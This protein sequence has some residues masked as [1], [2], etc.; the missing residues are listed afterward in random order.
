MKFSPLVLPNKQYSFI[1]V[2]SLISFV[3]SGVF[4]ALQTSLTLITMSIILAG[5][6]FVIFVYRREWFPFLLVF[7]LG[8]EQ[9]RLSEIGVWGTASKIG[10]VALVFVYLI[11]RTRHPSVRRKEFLSGPVI[12]L[13]ALF[14]FMLVS[15]LWSQ[16][17]ELGPV[18][19]T[20]GISLLAMSLLVLDFVEDEID[21]RNMC[22]A[23]LSYGLV[24]S[25][26]GIY[27][28]FQVSSFVTE[29]QFRAVSLTGN[30]NFTAAYNIIATAVLLG[31]TAVLTNPSR[32]TYILATGMLVILLV[33]TVLTASRAS[34]IA[35]GLVYLIAFI[36]AQSKKVVLTV[37][38][39]VMGLSL[40]AFIVVPQSIQ[41][42]RLRFDSFL[43]GGNSIEQLDTGL[44]LQ[45]I[46][47][48]LTIL[49]ESPIV[50]IGYGSFLTHPLNP[51]HRVTHG[52]FHGILVEGGIIGFILLM[53]LIA[54]TF[55]RLWLTRKSFTVSDNHVGMQV[56]LSLF[57][58]FVGFLFMAAFNDLAFT[59]FF[60]LLITLISASSSIA[61]EYQPK[62]S[63][64]KQLSYL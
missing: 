53:A 45:L 35:M 39:S 46:S 15:T 32:K 61:A 33:G 5:I 23:L 62:Y 19:L 13:I 48:S 49:P 25:L 21:L 43:M 3:F 6:L 27:Q 59:K 40:I 10:G 24:I 47:T 11:I 26:V 4:I 17:P 54:T 51:Y 2:L 28:F 36:M 9:L 42:M 60:W 64:P 20:T 56:A 1:L 30:S 29:Q 31:S 63:Q 57:L 14:L 44:R 12:L 37:I 7:V 34:L 18:F 55:I 38:M 16:Q 8:M 41:T 58:A 22:W 52:I 50:G